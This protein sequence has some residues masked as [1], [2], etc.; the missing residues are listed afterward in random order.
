MGSTNFAVDSDSFEANNTY[1]F[2]AFKAFNNVTNN[3]TDYFGM[4]DVPNNNLYIYSPLKLN[5]SKITIW[6][7]ASGQYNLCACKSGDVYGSTNKEKQTK[8]VNFTNSNTEWLGQWSIT[9]TNNGY[10]NYH[11]FN[12][13]ASYTS[14]SVVINEILLT[15]TCKL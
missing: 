14:T 15:A 9:T 2:R 3:H 13:T 4:T 1:N 12:A 11:I 10:Y 6:N 5:I 7:R 8:L